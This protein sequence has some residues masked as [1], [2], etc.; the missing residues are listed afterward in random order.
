MTAIRKADNESAGPLAEKPMYP[1]C[2]QFAICSFPRG[3]GPF[4][5]SVVPFHGRWP[6][7]KT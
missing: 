4:P 5:W 1:I 3:T 7:L 2:S 6:L